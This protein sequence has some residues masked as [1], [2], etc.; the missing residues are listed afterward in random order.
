MAVLSPTQDLVGVLHDHYSHQAHQGGPDWLRDLRLHALARFVELGWPTRQLEDWKYTD[1]AALGKLALKPAL[2]P[3]AERIAGLKGQALPFVPVDARQIVLVDGFV[4]PELSQLDGLEAGLTV[5][6]LADV[7]AK[8]PDSLQGVLAQMA[9]YVHS[10]MVALNTAGLA[11]GVVVRLAKDVTVRQ[12]LYVVSVTSAGVIAQPRLLIITERHSKLTVVETH[13]HQV[14]AVA[15]S[16]LVSEIV[17]GEG[18]TVEHYKLNVDGGELQHVA[19]TQAHQLG[20]SHYVSHAVALGGTLTRN[21]LGITLAGEGSDCILNGTYVG[22]G[23]TRIDNRTVIDHTKAYCSSEELYKGILDD[24]A[25]G[26]FS[27]KI[28]VR[29]QAQKTDSRQRNNNLLLSAD[30]VANTKPQLEIDADDVKCAHGATVGQ[31]DANAL[32]YLMSRGI[33][34]AEAR[35]LMTVAFAGEVTERITIDPLRQ[36][37]NGWLFAHLAKPATV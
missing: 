32:F 9:D 10:G 15:L 7:V 11:D 12:P 19:S 22:S 27:G 23:Q 37:L 3:T 21:D 31:I 33:D 13:V 28:I 20:H 8:N 25:V 24:H 5:E 30:A 26:S 36:G 29:P 14:D 16:N 2:P 4:V 35:G 17:V 18:A 1:L 6:S 34:A